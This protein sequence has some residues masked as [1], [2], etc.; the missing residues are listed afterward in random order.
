M[1][2]I[3]VLLF[4]VAPTVLRA[5]TVTHAPNASEPLEQRWDWAVR[6]AGDAACSDGCWIGYS[7]MRLMH[8]DSYIGSWSDRDDRPTLEELVYGRHTEHLTDNGPRG[9]AQPA[10]VEKEVAFLF[11]VEP[12]GGEVR[13]IRISN[14]SLSADLDGLPVLWLGKAGMPES[15][16]FVRERYG[17]AGS[18]ELKKDLVT[19]AGIHEGEASASSFLRQVLAGKDDDEV[20][21]QAAFWLA[22]QD[23]PE[24]AAVLEQ[25]AK[26][27][28]SEEVRE[29][30]VFG[31][32]RI[33]T[34][35]ATERLIGLAKGGADDSGTREKA[36]FWLGQKASQKAAETLGDIAQNDPNTEIQKKAVFAISQLPH[37]EGVPKLITIARTHRNAKVRQEAI[38]WLGQSGDARAVDVL[39]DIARGE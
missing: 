27:D 39:V 30:A 23:G 5:Q 17:K 33:D 37:D 28:R 31:L 18:T 13:D 10:K 15:I 32:S 36:I 4:L 7:I 6:Q 38:F 2:F 3:L 11:R 20:R 8:E 21:S 35:G 22:E 29:Q 26:Q 34:E 9:A 19:A 25:T 16:A 24:A 12:R 1:R 14:M